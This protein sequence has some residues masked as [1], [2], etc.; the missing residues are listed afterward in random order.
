MRKSWRKGQGCAFVTQV[1]CRIRFATITGSP[2]F[3]TKSSAEL[4]K[5]TTSL[6]GENTRNSI[7]FHYIEQHIFSHLEN[8]NLSEDKSAMQSEKSSD[9][10][11]LRPEPKL[12]EDSP[13]YY[14]RSLPFARNVACTDDKKHAATPKSSYESELR[15]HADSNIVFM[16]IGNKTNMK[17]LRAIATEDVTTLEP[18]SSRRLSRQFLQKFTGEAGYSPKMPRPTANKSLDKA[19]TIHQ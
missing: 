10:C 6:K 18:T 12:C 5:E 13:D 7:F 4:V 9:E 11:C 15:Y 16:L 19:N 17:H 8:W 2:H 3:V 14:N 1:V